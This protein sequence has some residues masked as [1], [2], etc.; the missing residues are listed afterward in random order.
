MPKHSWT[1]TAD[2]HQTST[3]TVNSV[4]RIFDHTAHDTVTAVVFQM[5]RMTNPYPALGHDHP[6]RDHGV[7]R[8]ERH[9][10][11]DAPLR[12]DLQRHEHRDAAPMAALTCDLDLALRTVSNCH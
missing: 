10:H 5:P 11:G 4:E 6:E 8:G 2:R 9:A 3:Y 7:H 1:G 12:R